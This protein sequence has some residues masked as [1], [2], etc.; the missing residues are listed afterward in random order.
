MKKLEDIPKKNIYNVPEGYFETLP[1]I[2]QSRVAATPTWTGTVSPY[3]RFIRYSIPALFVI[4]AAL[5]FLTNQPDEPGGP[6]EILSGITTE[7]L[8]NYLEEEW[9]GPMELIEDIEL[10]DDDLNNIENIVYFN[11]ENIHVEDE[12]LNDFLFE[13]DIAN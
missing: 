3:T 6:E 1:G 7:A 9:A 11:A 2:I 10:T 8:E 4:I 5:I 12:A 13:N